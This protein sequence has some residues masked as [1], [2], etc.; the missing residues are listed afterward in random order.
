MNFE[1]YS[2][3]WTDP[4]G[5]FG[6]PIGEYYF[7]DLFERAVARTLGA[8]PPTGYRRVS[9]AMGFTVTQDKL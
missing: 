7:R 2:T 8:V 3:G 9:Y 1:R 5:V 6:T 4:R